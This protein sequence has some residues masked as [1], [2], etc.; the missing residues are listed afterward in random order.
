MTGV[1]VGQAMFRG[2]RFILDLNFFCLELIFVLYTIFPLSYICVLNIF[3]CLFCK[4]PSIPM[5]YVVASVSGA[6]G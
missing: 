1:C 5:R 6:A 3:S 4:N 2:R